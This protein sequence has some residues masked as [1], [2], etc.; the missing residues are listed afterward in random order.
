MNLRRTPLPRGGRVAGPGRAARFLPALLV[1]LLGSGCGAEAVERPTPLF[2]EVPIDYPLELWDRDV[3]G[4]TLLRVRV[5]TAGR[6][7]SLE[8][9]ES[10]GY[11]AFDSAALEGA[12][13][14]RF[15]PARRGGERI[16]VW[17]RVPV[18]FSKEPRPDS[19]GS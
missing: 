5:D 3:E 4:R 19:T 12:Q 2:E 7:D 10:S 9:L 18:H 14:L 15:R 17:A 13:D 11:P 6:V 16:P 1:A 8:V